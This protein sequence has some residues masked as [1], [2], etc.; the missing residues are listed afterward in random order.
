[1]SQNNG[2]ESQLKCS[3][4]KQNNQFKQQKTFSSAA[5]I[6]VLFWV[7]EFITLKEK[8][9]RNQYERRQLFGIETECDISSKCVD[10]DIVVAQSNKSSLLAYY[11]SLYQC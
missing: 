7:V 2:C 4:N 10:T 11:P 5:F 9:K 6:S 3:E 1:M 8:F